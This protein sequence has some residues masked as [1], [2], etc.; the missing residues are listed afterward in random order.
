VRRA[1]AAALVFGL[2][3]SVAPP[4]TATPATAFDAAST[5]IARYRE[6]I[7]FPLAWVVFVGRRLFQLVAIGAATVSPRDG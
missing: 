6:R 5:V 3:T 4:G 1:V 7:V 2:A